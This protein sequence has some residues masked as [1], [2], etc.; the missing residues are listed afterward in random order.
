MMP[1]AFFPLR[2]VVLCVL[3]TGLAMTTTAGQGAGLVQPFSWRNETWQRAADLRVDDA[4]AQLPPGRPTDGASERRELDYTRGVLLLNAQPKT[5]GNV[6]RAQQLFESVCQTVADDDVGLSA[7]YLLGR[8]AEFHADPTDP[9]R[10]AALYEELIAR[11]A[12]HPLAQEAMSRLA[13]LRLFEEVPPEERRA[14]LAN[15]STVAD[16]L[17]SAPARRDLHLVLAEALLTFSDDKEGALRHL[18]AAEEAGIVSP[19]LVGETLARIAVL[20]RELGHRDVAITHYKNFLAGFE[21]DDRAS[22]LAGQ[23][24]ALEAEASTPSNP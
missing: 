4:L 17:S 20:A 12:T 7:L 21:R 18:L 11:A 15:F 13:A 16:D 19:Q 23:L 3:A 22:L 9:V 2:K 1:R 8:I 6:R 10:A 24:H 5:Q 14:R